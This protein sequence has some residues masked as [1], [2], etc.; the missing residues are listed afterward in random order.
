MVLA[1][2][3][4]GIGGLLPSQAAHQVGGEPVVVRGDLVLDPSVG[5]HRL[6]GQACDGLSEPG[7]G[8]PKLGGWQL[9]RI[10]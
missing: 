10:D 6:L 2:H 1:R 3:L 5:V 8:E 4:F 9:A 7:H